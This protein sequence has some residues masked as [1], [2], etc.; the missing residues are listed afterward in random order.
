MTF[1]KKLILSTLLVFSAMAFSGLALSGLVISEVIASK[2]SD[3]GGFDILLITSV[4][5][6][7]FCS[8]SLF[9]A[10]KYG[11]VCFSF[12][13]NWK[14]SFVF[15]AIAGLFIINIIISLILKWFD[16]EVR[17]YEDLNMDILRGNPVLFLVAIVVIAPLYEEFVFRGFLLK[18]FLTQEIKSHSHIRKWQTILAVFITSVL[19]SLVHF[20]QDSTLSIFF[21]IFILAVYLSFITLYT[22]SILLTSVVHSVNNLISG[23]TLL[24]APPIS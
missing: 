12:R 3:M 16:V 24:Y 19:F 10:R 22:Q 15:L 5:A 8:F 21:P 18:M 11:F 20:S 13:K 7:F 6:V 2:A 14:S 1:F 4:Q 23:L 17:Q 9:L